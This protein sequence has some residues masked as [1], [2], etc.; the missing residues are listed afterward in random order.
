MGFDALFPLTDAL[1]AGAY[2]DF[3]YF[4][5]DMG[6]KLRYTVLGGFL[7]AEGSL[8]VEPGALVPADV[9][10]PEA[11]LD[12]LSRRPALRGV[13]RGRLTLN[14]R[15]ERFWLYDR[16]TLT[17]RVRTFAELDPY[18][19]AR[20]DEELSVENALAPMV[21]IARWGE[22][23]RLWAY[24]EL[25]V[26]AEA[27]AG[28]LDLRP[29]VGLIAEELLEGLTLD[30]DLYRSFREGTRLEGFGVLLFVWWTP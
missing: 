18:R 1:E 15:D 30:L 14:L 24:A 11:P 29:S 6:A 9:P 25:T 17:G 8:G 22:A 16:L 28:L 23:S 3:F 2:L 12:E 26:E 27:R 7:V 19:A 5:A 21:Q 20:L 10:D 4:W 13:A